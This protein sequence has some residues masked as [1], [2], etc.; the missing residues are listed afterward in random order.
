MSAAHM[1]VLYSLLV[2]LGLSLIG[3]GL[4]GAFRPRVGLTWRGAG[5]PADGAGWRQRGSLT[6]RAWGP[7]RKL[8]T[9]GMFSQ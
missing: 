2:L 5:A 7:G 8:S 4:V 1:A 6:R 9:N 3:P